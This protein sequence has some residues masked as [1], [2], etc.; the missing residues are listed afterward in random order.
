MKT[1]IPPLHCRAIEGVSALH[2]S[3]EAGHR[4]AFIW[5]I[6]A[7]DMLIGRSLIPG[8]TITIAGPPGAGKTILASTLC[9]HNMVRG[10]RCLYISFQEHYDKF[11]IYM[12]RLGMDFHKFKKM[13][14]F[15]Y[16]AYPI[17]LDR[18][19]LAHTLE[20]IA[21]R[22][23]S[24]E[25]YKIVVIDS[26]NPLAR[27]AGG[28]IK[29]REIFAN[30]FYNLARMRHGIVVLIAE[31]W[32]ERKV[33]LQGLEYVADVILLLGYRF[34]RG[35]MS[36]FMR[37]V[38][39]RGAPIY[40]AE[41]PFSIIE[42]KGIVV[43]AQPPLIREIPPPQPEK[44]IKS[45]CK[46]MEHVFKLIPQGS[47]IAL[48]YQ[49]DARGHHLLAPLLVGLIFLQNVRT[50]FF[51]YAYSPEEIVERLLWWLTSDLR[52]K[53]QKKAFDKQRLKIISINPGSLSLSE[54]Y[55]LEMSEIDE[56]KP[57]LVVFD[58]TDIPYLIHGV[59]DEPA[60]ITNLRNELIDLRRRNITTIRIQIELDDKFYRLNAGIAN[61]VIRA[62]YR[63]RAGAYE[64]IVYVW[65][66]NSAPVIVDAKTLEECA[67]Q[68]ES[69]LKKVI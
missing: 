30:F 55:S 6:D 24:R 10:D 67:K 64:P 19:W 51:S 34:Q 58:R 22:A 11:L 35:F 18:D 50:L 2:G 7:L 37:I 4:Q 9:Y 12:R 13:G 38:K 41:I 49:A 57:N 33:D 53:V 14:L 65:R 20:N 60:Y 17:I 26:V 66:E 61:V 36:R 1:V 16:E 59:I 68:I 39:A 15:D 42:G 29:A 8:S 69:E 56:F 28:D 23:F 5:G 21:K 44:H 46:A 47:H 48:F 3:R 54:I 62:S 27:I 52:E 32:P 31:A 45:P 25:D 63:E 43:H 40:L